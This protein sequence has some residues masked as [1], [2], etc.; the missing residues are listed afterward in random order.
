MD[1]ED[2]TDF[3]AG[4]VSKGE[5]QALFVACLAVNENARLPEAML[6]PKGSPGSGSS[7]SN[8]L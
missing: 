7:L 6:L 2:W 4:N 3:L 1:L 5:K 8:L